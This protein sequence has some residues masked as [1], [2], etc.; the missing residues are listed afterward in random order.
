MATVYQDR[1]I[2]TSSP[3]LVSTVT[4][5]S[6]R[7]GNTQYYNLTIAM[8]TNSSAGYWDFPWVCKVWANGIEVVGSIQI[9][10]TTSGVLG[11]TWYSNSVT[12]S[13][14]TS[15]SSGSIPIS[16]N[17]YNT[18][19]NGKY[20]GNGSG[21]LDLNPLSVIYLSSPSKT[22]TSISFHYDYGNISPSHI[23][24]YNG[25]TFLGE[26]YSQDFTVYGLS[27]N[28]TYSD[29]KAYGYA[30]G[31]YGPNGN[32]ISVKTYPTPVSVGSVIVNEITPFTAKVNVTSS[33]S[34][35]TN[36]IEYTILDSGGS[37]VSDPITSTAYNYTF[38]SLNPET[39]Y[40]ARVRVRT[41]E[42]NIWSGYSTINFVTLSDQSQAWLKISGTWKKGKLFTKVNGTWRVVKEAF[43]KENGTWRKSTNN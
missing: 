26:F 41:S 20:N 24:L 32:S 33:N 5:D 2:T 29:L 36:L 27:P 34:A 18:S 19:V 4:Y 30:N 22:D 13:V 38:S 40:Q 28:T 8:R 3:G 23:H 10:P 6:W 15:A 11:Y 43:N 39:S 21:Y 9:K 42:S 12:F 14:N 17:Y 35:F 31:G 25:G 7:S 1:I 37:I 16:I